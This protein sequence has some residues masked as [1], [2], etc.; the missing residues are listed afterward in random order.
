MFFDRGGGGGMS[1]ISRQREIHRSPIIR[2]LAVWP[3]PGTAQNPPTMNQKPARTDT[4]FAVTWWRNGRYGE[5][6]LRCSYA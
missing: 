3:D 6:D 4:R 2:A 1:F 5:S